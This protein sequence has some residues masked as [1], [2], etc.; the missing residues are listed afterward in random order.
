MEWITASEKNTNRFE[1]EKSIDGINWFYIGEKPAAG[2]STQR[3]SYELYDNFPL[4][5]NNYY[6]LKTIDNDGTFNYS[7]IVNIILTSLNSSS[8]I[9]GA[10]PNPTSSNVMVVIA[11]NTIQKASLNVYDVLGKIVMTTNVNLM[12]G[13]NNETLN[14]SALA[15]A[16]YLIILT[17]EKG[18]QYKYKIVKQ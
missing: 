12:E 7:K 17:D 1:V 5:G 16:T 8:G 14:F 2:N 13:I 18:Y 11:S 3:L 6:R 10:Y 4:V 15:N 9:V